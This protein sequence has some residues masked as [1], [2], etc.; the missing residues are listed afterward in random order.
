[1]AVAVDC[2]AFGPMAVTLGSGP[3]ATR[4]TGGGDRVR[5]GL[6]ALAVSRRL[7]AS[8]SRPRGGAP[9]RKRGTRAARQRPDAARRRHGTALGE[10]AAPRGSTRAQPGLHLGTDGR[11][12]RLPLRSEAPGI[13]EPRGGRSGR[14]FPHT[15]GNSLTHTEK[16]TAMLVGIIVRIVKALKKQKAGR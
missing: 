13:A 6:T 8:V 1:M 15:D 12:I 11:D 16:G 3:L 5:T 2:L 14:E 7:L 9:L 4:R 10:R